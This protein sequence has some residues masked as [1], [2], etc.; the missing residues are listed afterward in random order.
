M[1][2]PI[3]F[4]TLIGHATVTKSPQDMA[5]LET[6]LAVMQPVAVESPY[7]RSVTAVCRGLFITISAA[8]IR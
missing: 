7:V 4:I 1:V 5:L 2:P 8:V 6:A 3:P